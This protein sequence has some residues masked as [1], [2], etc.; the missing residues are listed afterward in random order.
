MIEFKFSNFFRL[1]LVL[2][3]LNTLIF[4]VKWQPKFKGVDPEAQIYVNDWF[5]LA[6]LYG[7]KFNN[8]VTIGFANINEP[9]VVAQ[10]EYG[11]GFREITINT[12]YWDNMDSMDRFITIAHE[13][14]HCN[15]N[16]GHQFGEGRTKYSDDGTNPQEGFFKDG[17]PKSIMYPYT[18]YRG[19]VS[20]HF[21]EYVNDMF[22]NC[23]P[24]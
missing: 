8:R 6:T 7:I 19:C 15:C 5:D 22:K 20:E 11:M 16:E 1:F 9:N 24:Y 13:S 4:K 23:N 18:M 2:F 3:T 21:Q 17:C 10:C 14:G 12:K